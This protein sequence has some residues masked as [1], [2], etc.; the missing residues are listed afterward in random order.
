MTNAT[1][2]EP[3]EVVIDGETVE[4]RNV[5][6]LGSN[7][8]ELDEAGAKY[9]RSWI[10]FPTREAA[11]EAARERWQDMA[12]ND[13]KEF[14]CMVGEETLIAWALGR[15]GGHAGCSSLE[16]FLDLIADNPCEEFAGYD[17]EEREMTDF[18][19]E[20]ADELN[21]PEVSTWVAYRSN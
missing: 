12:E 8:Y 2:C 20:I 7:G 1:K 16:Q 14:I 3:R 6:D 10:V 17:G 9:G 4:I 19:V 11:G 15:S 5:R 18:G 13:P 21:A